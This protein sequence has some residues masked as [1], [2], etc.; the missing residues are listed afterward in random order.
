MGQERHLTNFVTL[1]HVSF[2]LLSVYDS[3]SILKIIILSFLCTE[4]YIFIEKDQHSFSKF[5]SQNKWQMLILGED[6]VEVER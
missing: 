4:I 1:K 2:E 3:F 6:D 5:I